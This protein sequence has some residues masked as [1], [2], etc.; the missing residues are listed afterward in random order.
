MEIDEAEFGRRKYRRERLSQL[1]FEA[2]E[3]S[4]DRLF[5]VLVEQ[6]SSEVSISIIH[7]RILP[8]TISDLLMD[9]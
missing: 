7:Q 1:L 9:T 6:R 4:T 8:D 5:I 2:I 3:E